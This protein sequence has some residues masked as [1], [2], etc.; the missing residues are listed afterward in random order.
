[1]RFFLLIFLMATLASGATP[2]AD[3]VKAVYAKGLNLYW[4][5]DYEDAS[6]K[7]AEV[8]ESSPVSLEGSRA[9]YMLGILRSKMDSRTTAKLDRTLEKRYPH[10][11]EYLVAMRTTP[12]RPAES[13]FVQWATFITSAPTPGWCTLGL[14]ALFDLEW[15]D[16]VIAAQLPTATLC[17]DMALAADWREKPPR[18][19]HM[20]AQL[21]NQYAARG[22]YQRQISYRAQLLS[23]ASSPEEVATLFSLY[24]SSGQEEEAFSLYTNQLARINEAGRLGQLIIRDLISKHEVRLARRALVELQARTAP[25]ETPVL[26]AEAMILEAE[27]QPVAAQALLTGKDDF[28]ILDFMRGLQ[29]RLPQQYEVEWTVDLKSGNNLGV[30]SSGIIHIL[31]TRQPTVVVARLTA[32]GKRLDDITIQTP[33]NGTREFSS[34]SAFTILPDNRYLIGLAIYTAEGIRSE[35]IT[36][37]NTFQRPEEI[38]RSAISPSGEIYVLTRTSVQRVVSTNGSNTLVNADFGPG[39]MGRPDFMQSAARGF[40]DLAWIDNGWVYFGE[41][42][43]IKTSANWNPPRTY[44]YELTRKSAIW[45]NLG[46]LYAR[47]DSAGLIYLVS[48]ATLG[49][50]V[51]DKD[52]QLLC[53]VINPRAI[54]CQPAEDGSLYVLQMG[55]AVTKYRPIA[56]G[57]RAIR[58]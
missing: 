4:N 15:S 13:N 26:I 56:G 46:S 37:P 57:A 49:V 29:S 12:Q 24:R 10:M 48:P 52:F 9:A 20:Q 25:M 22:D 42:E 18:L 11:A 21:L 34:R 14:R 3:Q 27:Q 39:A 54:V 55:G 23:L 2:P 35:S 47:T 41:Y 51:L 36:S 6:L 1:M 38:F 17:M 32:D 58:R 30:D 28:E 19:L 50:S 8:L 45:I 40:H 44:P 33:T 16:D 5:G 7:M 53:R 43:A 31:Q